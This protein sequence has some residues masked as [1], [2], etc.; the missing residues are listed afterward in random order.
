MACTV[1]DQGWQ[2]EQAFCCPLPPQMLPGAY[3]PPGPTVAFTA[4]IATTAAR[5]TLGAQNTYRG[6]VLVEAKK[7]GASGLTLASVDLQSITPGQATLAVRTQ[8][9]LKAGQEAAAQ[10]LSNRLATNPDAPWLDNLWPGSSVSDV[11]G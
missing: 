6:L 9:S 3:P 2:A 4:Q 10:T 7:A 5:F 11:A 1:G 8:V